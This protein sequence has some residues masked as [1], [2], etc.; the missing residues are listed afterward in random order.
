MQSYVHVGNLPH[1]V[2]SYFVVLHCILLS[3]VT[4][5]DTKESGG[6]ERGKL[7]L[8]D[9][10]SLVKRSK[11]RYRPADATRRNSSGGVGDSVGAREKTA[12]WEFPHITP[13]RRLLL[14]GWMKTVGK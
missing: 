9:W 4:A 12:M 10:P 13:S 3:S 8:R 6:T 7:L 2:N 5:L 14:R 1:I 11:C